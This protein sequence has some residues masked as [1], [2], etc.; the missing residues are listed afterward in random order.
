MVDTFNFCPGQK[1]HCNF[2]KRLLYVRKTGSWEFR[3]NSLN[4]A[5][6]TNY[7]IGQKKSHVPYQPLKGNRLNAANIGPTAT[8]P[9]KDGEPRQ[10]RIEPWQRRGHIRSLRGGRHNSHQCRDSPWCVVLCVVWRRQ[11]E[12]R[13]R[14]CAIA[15][16]AMVLVNDSVCCGVNI[17]R[18][19][20]LTADIRAMVDVFVGVCSRVGTRYMSNYLVFC[21]K[22]LY[23]I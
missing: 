20:P 9:S 4:F 7:R 11:R 8:L 22:C 5:S 12:S 2:L 3:I 19:F 14:V 15:V 6:T 13:R 10:V 23:R 18:Q 1:C 16:S 21:R 17:G